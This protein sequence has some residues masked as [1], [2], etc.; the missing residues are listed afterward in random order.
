MF[1]A[2][3]ALIQLASASNLANSEAQSPQEVKLLVDAAEQNKTRSVTAALSGI[4]NK[5]DNS[6]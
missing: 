5:L 1:S 2:I 4:G 3:T 6:A